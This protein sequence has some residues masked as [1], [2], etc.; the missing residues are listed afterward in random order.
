MFNLATSERIL[1]RAL[2]ATFNQSLWNDQD[3]SLI[4]IDI[5]S[6]VRPFDVAA[7]CKALF[8]ITAA[9]ALTD[10][11]ACQFQSLGAQEIN[12]TVKLTRSRVWQAQL[13]RLLGAGHLPIVMPSELLALCITED[14]DAQY[15]RLTVR[16][17]TTRVCRTA[18]IPGQF[19]LKQVHEV[20]CIKEADEP[21]DQEG[22]SRQKA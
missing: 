8:R 22:S 10:L 13:A 3:Y 1:A 12:G 11:K 4:R 7:S 16:D 15:H 5:R 6:Q 17:V 21:A 9:S 20:P 2:R 18:I 14:A 19:S